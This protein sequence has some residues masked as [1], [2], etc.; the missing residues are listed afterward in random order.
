MKKLVFLFLLIV[1]IPLSAQT[2][3]IPARASGKDSLALAQMMPADTLPVK[4][5]LMQDTVLPRIVYFY[6]IPKP[7][8]VP[9]EPEFE[10]FSAYDYIRSFYDNPVLWQDTQHPFRMYLGRVLQKIDEQPFDSIRQELTTYPYE[11]MNIPW[12][13][14]YLWDSIPVPTAIQVQPEDTLAAGISPE[15]DT[16]Q[17]DSL[18]LLSPVK[19]SAVFVNA[20]SLL[21]EIHLQG[22][23]NTDSLRQERQIAD[24]LLQAEQ[25]GFSD[26]LQVQTIPLQSTGPDSVILVVIDSLTHL[27]VDHPLFPFRGLDYAGVGDSLQ[28]AVEVLLDHIYQTDSSL[29]YLQNL[30]SSET[31]MWMSANNQRAQRFWLR[32]SREDS[33]TVW[34]SNPEKNMLRLA[35]DDGVDFRNIRKQRQIE[36]V[37]L[38]NLRMPQNLQ[39]AEK[40]KIKPVLW[41]YG[42]TSQFNLSQGYIS[43]W[44]KG[45]ES[46]ITGLL[47]LNGFV[48]YNNKS[49]K[50]NWT[51]TLRQKYG[52]MYSK[53]KNVQKNT[54]LLEYT[55]KFGQK[56][57][58]RFDVSSKMVFKSQLTKGYKYPNDS[59]VVSRFFNPA[60][61]VV[62]VG[63]DYKPNKKTSIDFSPL[64]YKG[65]FVLDTANIKQTN[66]GV[67]ADKR[68]RHEPGASVYLNHKFSPFEDVTM[69]NKLNVFT[70]YTEFGTLDIDWEMTLSAEINW[71]T[72][73]NINTHLIYDDDVVFD[74]PTEGGGTKKQSKV[75]FKELLSFG[76]KFTF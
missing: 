1:S 49:K 52:L 24:S 72:T 69:E 48:N 33:V 54:D 18:R 36:E 29:L 35:L 34:V 8:A 32:N 46:A 39:E 43:Y 3:T 2:D 25:A 76:F 75:Q 60:N 38:H 31:P 30:S 64:T 74:V 51:N 53:S 16:I 15:A 9:V 47:D 67:A 40:V 62:S 11:L 10:V 56:A 5:S 28:K 4:D 13:S 44:A 66:Y 71:F 58:G 21:E 14:F 19:D 17:I 57:F 45:G 22:V 41:T 63:I 59:V 37:K 23:G 55:S 20:D 50:I 7:R 70:N 73:V 61:L 6:N 68:S 65:T 42:A 27:R 26:S 12:T